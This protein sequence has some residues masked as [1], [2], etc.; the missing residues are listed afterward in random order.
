MKETKSSNPE[1]IQ[2]IRFLMKRSKENNVAIWRDVAGYLAKARRRRVAV[3][4]SRINRYTQ[5]SDVVIV[6]GKILGAGTL[7]HSVTV[8]AFS[9]SEKAKAKIAAAKAKYLSIPELVETNPK[10]SNVKII[11]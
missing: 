2:L 4:L 9:V 7:D 6:P 8:A 1:L 11:R 10:G 3:N 5:K